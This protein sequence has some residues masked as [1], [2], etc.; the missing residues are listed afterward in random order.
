MWT[1]YLIS[2]AERSPMFMLALVAIVV[3]IVR[4][5]RHPGVSGLITIAFILYLLKSFTFAFVFQWLPTLEESMHLSW[6][7]I[8]T[9]GTLTGVVSDIFF[10]VVLVMLVVAAFS[11]RSDVTTI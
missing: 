2:L 10:S 5:R 11:K 1:N 4:W 8:D 3:A 7:K 9:L 6:D